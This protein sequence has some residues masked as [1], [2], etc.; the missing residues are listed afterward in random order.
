MY[1]APKRGKHKGDSPAPLAI[2]MEV[3]YQR[4]FRRQRTSFSRSNQPAKNFV[5]VHGSALT[6]FRGS[7]SLVGWMVGWV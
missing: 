7:F 5:G 4:L 2:G 1:A 3:F 6:Y